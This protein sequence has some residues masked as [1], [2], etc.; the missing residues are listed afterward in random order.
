MTEA[1]PAY[2]QAIE[3]RDGSQDGTFV[4]AVKTTRIFCRPSCPSRRPL[5]VNVQYFNAP[6]AAEAAGYRACKRCRPQDAVHPEASLMGAAC[7]Y[8][9]DH[10][11][12][13]QLSGLARHMGYSPFHIQRL[14]KSALGITPRAYSESRRL[15]ALKKDLRENH[16]VTESLYNAGYC[17]SSR[18]Y[19][20]SGAQFGMTP[21]T[22]RKQGRGTQ[23]GF[24]IAPSS[25]GLVL[26][27]QTSRG[28]C[29]IAFGASESELE[30]ALR[31]EFSSATITKAHSPHIAALL[32]HLHGTE[33]LLRL[34]L[35]IQATAFQRRVWEQLQKIPY[36]ETRS[37]SKIAQ[38][39]EQPT[40]ARAVARACAANPVAL[41]IPCHRVVREG[42]ALSGY[43]WGVNRKQ[44]LLDKERE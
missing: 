31:K 40:A 28:V 39:L 13:F 24:T 44:A 5:L 3:S 26:V 34:P 33:R 30:S 15:A 35:D 8:I 42:G 16:P 20:N 7:R 17:S 21:A 25:L 6:A 29:S 1:A 22:Y 43:R 12:G 18:V 27:A 23:I 14:F 19:E 9:E 36:G 4:Y 10:R 38:A 32:A 41:A 11:E 37:Y 2:W